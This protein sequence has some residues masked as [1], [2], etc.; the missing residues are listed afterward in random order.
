MT[1]PSRRALLA[2]APALY[3][4]AILAALLDF[5][6]T[7]RVLIGA[8]VVAG[9][10]AIYVRFV[11]PRRDRS[12]PGR[13]HRGLHRSPRPGSAELP[14]DRKV[15]TMPALPTPAGVPATQQQPPVCREAVPLI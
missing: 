11:L 15:L 4:V 12:A 13:G 6:A 2:V 7:A 3:P 9:A 1:P 5:R 10:M 8:A 14:D